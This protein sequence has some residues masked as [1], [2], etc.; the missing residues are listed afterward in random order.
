[1]GLN[2]ERKLLR[3]DR[4]LRILGNQDL[5]FMQD[6]APS[7]AARETLR[8]LH[9]RCVS[10]IQWP[11]YSGFKSNCDSLELDKGLHSSEFR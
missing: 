8:E 2:F 1:M 6:G 7:H 11:A 9:E 4:W 5:S 10:L 3:P